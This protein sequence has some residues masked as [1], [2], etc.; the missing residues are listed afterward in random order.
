MRAVVDSVIRLSGLQ[1]KAHEILWSG[2]TF[3]NPEYLSRVRFNRWVGATPEE[4]TLL[5]PGNGGEV[6]VPRGAVGLV[7]PHDLAERWSAAFSPA[8]HLGLRSRRAGS[9][10]SGA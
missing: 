2:L 8:W 7:R 9:E 4:I 1:P 10:R 6:I 5:E 3:P